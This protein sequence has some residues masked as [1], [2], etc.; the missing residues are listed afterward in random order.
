MEDTMNQPPV[1][2]NSQPMP[3]SQPTPPPVQPMPEANTGSGTNTNDD[4]A[5]NKGM[6][7]AACFIF[8]L[9]LLTDAKHSKFAMFWANQSLLRLFVHIAAMVV[10]IIPV[11][12]WIVGFVLHIFGLVLFILSIVHAANGEMKPLPIIG[13]MAEILKVS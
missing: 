7:I 3:A 11:L 6:A 2:Q 12:G 13:T 10:M 5:K 4:V 8:F 1:P 9:P